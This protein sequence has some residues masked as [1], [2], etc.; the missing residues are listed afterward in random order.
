MVSGPLHLQ[1]YLDSIFDPEEEETIDNL[2]RCYFWMAFGGID[3]EDTILIKTEDVDLE[4]M[5]IRYKSVSVPIYR[6]ALPAFRNAITLNSFL[7]KHPK[8]SKLIRRERIPG[9]T[10]M[11]GIK[12]TTKTFT[13]R[14]T[15]SKRNI[16]AIEEG[17]TDLQLSFY[18]VRMSG[19]FYRTY[20]I[21]RAGG[22]V[23][24]S[25]AA[26]RLMDGKTYSLS[27][28]EKIEHKQRRIE[29]DYFEDYQR[30]KLAFSM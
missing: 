7:Y 19:L 4:N 21:E 25:D 18:R 30:W 9:D 8:Y 27:G 2:Y 12:A 16:K 15:L 17:K 20:E 22:T 3:E 10:I 13:M 28:R 26:L 6:D 29:R 23:D 24:F 5:E 14:T 1:K 11:R